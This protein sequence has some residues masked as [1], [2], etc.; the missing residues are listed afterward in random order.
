MATCKRVPHSRPEAAAAQR[1]A[2]SIL[3]AALVGLALAGPGLTQSE[4][5]LFLETSDSDLRSAANGRIVVRGYAV[6]RGACSGTAQFDT[7]HV[8]LDGPAGI[9]G[10]VW[11][12]SLSSRS[13]VAR[14]YRCGA[15]TR[16]GFSFALGPFDTG[17]QGGHTLYL[18]AFFSADDERPYWTVP[19]RITPPDARIEQCKSG[20][21]TLRY[22]GD[23]LNLLDRSCET[24]PAGTQDA[25]INAKLRELERFLDDQLRR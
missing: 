6:R 24:D 19:F 25:M 4:D 2:A 21:R 5:T 16:S 23:L 12:Q 7:L 11:A 17:D 10:L 3:L 1:A 8:Y 15:A 9:G 13:D 18:Y 14:A 22:S 20:A